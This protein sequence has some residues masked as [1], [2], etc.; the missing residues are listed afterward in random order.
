M[1]IVQTYLVT[2]TCF[3][4]I[5]VYHCRMILRVMFA[6]MFMGSYIGLTENTGRQ[7]SAT[8]MLL[9]LILIIL[10]SYETYLF[11]RWMWFTLLLC[12]LLWLFFFIFWKWCIWALLDDGHFNMLWLLCLSSGACWYCSY[13]TNF[14]V[15][16]S[17]LYLRYA[18][19]LSQRR[20]IPVQ[21]VSV[22]YLKYLEN[23]IG[24]PPF[25]LWSCLQGLLFI[26]V[27]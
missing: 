27:Y 22:L 20:P 10:K 21:V 24:F 3:M 13:V 2:L 26:I 14:S 11:Y 8:V 15:V 4:W 12:C 9:R 18:H 6:G 25:V 16:G 17:V 23:F 1:G 19:K 5:L 7:L